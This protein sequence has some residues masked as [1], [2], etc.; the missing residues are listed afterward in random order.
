MAQITSSITLT[1]TSYTNTGNY[2][3]TESTSYPWTNAYNNSQSTTY[4]QL[5][6]AKNRQNTRQSQV[7]LEFD[8]SQLDDI[9]SN[10]TINSVQCYIKYYVSD[11]RYV[12]AFS[13]STYTNTTQKGT[14]LTSRPTSATRSQ[15]T[16]GTWTLSELKNARIYISA[17]HSTSNTNAFLYLYGADITVNYTYEGYNITAT[18][19]SNTV[20]VSPSTQSVG[21]GGDAVVM[22]NNVSDPSTILLKDNGV[23]VTNQLEQEYPQGTV[24]KI[25]NAVVENT[26]QADNNYPATN[27]LTGTESTTYA[28][29]NLS[30]TQRYIIYS[31]D[32][33]EIPNDASIL[34]VECQVHAYVTST[35]S[36]IT[37]KSAQLYAGTTAKGSTTTIPTTNS[38]WTISN[39]GTWT[40]SEIHNIR[41]R[42][43]GY[44]SG[45]STYYIRFYGA[46]LTVTYR[47][48]NIIYIYTISNVQTDHTIV[49]EDNSSPYTNSK[50]YIKKNGSFLESTNQYVKESN[51]WINRTISKIFWKINGSWTETNDSMSGK[52]AFKIDV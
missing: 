6:L 23:D 51:S 1:P 7:Y 24:D 40:V 30:P 14:A 45:S 18:S 49:V 42:F 5:T 10:A 33:S 31:F 4:A 39:V 27:G 34:S 41:L 36:N 2:A 16:M 38:T 15:I 8:T 12:T 29:L 13:A 50:Q 44:Y 25:P 3:F 46:N 22:L 32:T 37:T 48:N 43:D 21:A 11:T 35:S 19:N 47:S 17:T 28:R 26:F 9:P 52:T 20:T